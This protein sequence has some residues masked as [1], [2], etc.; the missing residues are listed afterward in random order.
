MV[1]GK[2][3][4]VGIEDG[5]VIGETDLAFRFVLGDMTV[6]LPKNQVEWDSDGRIMTM[7]EWLAVEKGLV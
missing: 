5:V 3:D 6:W 7:P 4:L 1:S 2:S